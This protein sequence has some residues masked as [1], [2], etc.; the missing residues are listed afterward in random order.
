MALEVFFVYFLV[1][2][3]R[4]E[5]PLSY[6]EVFN[7]TRIGDNWFSCIL[8]QSFYPTSIL[9]TH[10]EKIENQGNIERRPRKRKKNYQQE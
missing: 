3:T 8:L 9:C 2:K 10:N 4:E 6:K 1:N 5:L 7:S